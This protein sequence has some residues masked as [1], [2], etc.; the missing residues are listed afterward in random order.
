VIML[1]MPDSV[2]PR[3]L[4]FGYGQYLGYADGKYITAPALRE[5]FPAARLV[6]LTVTG[7]TLDADGID[8]EPGNPDA[9]A[10][11]E[12]VV[13][14]LATLPSQRPVIYADLGSPGYRMADILQ[15]MELHRIARLAVRLLSAHYGHGP[16]VCGPLSCGQIDIEMDGTQWTNDFTGIGANVDMSLLRDDF[17]G[18]VPPVPAW[19]EAMMQALPVVKLGSQ[20]EQVR[21]VQGL[22]N[23]RHVACTVDGE[24]GP[25]TQAAVETVQSGKVPVDGVVGP[26]TWPVLMGVA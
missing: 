9:R 18:P 12:W 6:I 21:T 5:L 2:R 22:C 7:R 3:T 20:G 1:H 10:A 14:K 26:Q 19:Q 13:S 11:V 8:C 24:F 4:P 23:A 15:E 25:D 17:W 16:H